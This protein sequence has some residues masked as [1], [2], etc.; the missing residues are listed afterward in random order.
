[1]KGQDQVWLKQ[2]QELTRNQE[3]RLEPA[4]AG[5][6]KVED[7][8]TAIRFDSD[9]EGGNLSSATHDQRLIIMVRTHSSDLARFRPRPNLSSLLPPVELGRLP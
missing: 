8:R 1:M 7:P 9:F 5:H 3:L 4:S 2:Q 6:I